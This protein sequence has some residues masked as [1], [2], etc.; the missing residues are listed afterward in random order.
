MD[1]SI[2]CH[3]AGFS[4]FGQFLYRSEGICKLLD[5]YF[6]T[7]STLT[8]PSSN[9]VNQQ[10]LINLHDCFCSNKLTVNNV[11]SCCMHIGSSQS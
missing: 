1:S 6:A 7:Y 8:Y 11:K 9:E 3:V 5:F 2:T 4:N 10:F